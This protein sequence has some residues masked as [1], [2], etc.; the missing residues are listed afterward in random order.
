M[1]TEGNDQ[2]TPKISSGRG[3]TDG[4]P[5]NGFTKI[6]QE[7]GLTKREYFAAM[8]TAAIAQAPANAYPNDVEANSDF[9]VKQADALISSLNKEK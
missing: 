7:G 5:R 3:F 1:K 9:G 4:N 8:F 6:Y 2:I